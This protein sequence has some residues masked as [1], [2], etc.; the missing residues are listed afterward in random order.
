[1]KNHP[2]VKASLALITFVCVTVI[3]IAGVLLW[4]FF[5]EEPGPEQGFETIMVATVMSP[6]AL[7]IGLMMAIEAV[8]QPRWLWIIVPLLVVISVFAF[9]T[10]MVTRNANQERREQLQ[11]GDDRLIQR[12]SQSFIA[13][14]AG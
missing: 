6:A 8:K 5:F 2:V 3:Y 9:V 10:I 7:L 4:I 12:S 13:P 11:Q 14:E 1:M